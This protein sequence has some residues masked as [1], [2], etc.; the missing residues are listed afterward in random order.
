MA[1][2]TVQMHRGMLRLSRILGARVDNNHGE[3]LGRI[4]D[5]IANLYDG[6]VAAVVLSFRD[7]AEIS[8]K[9]VAVPLA[10]L[11][12]ELKARNLH[13]NVARETLHKAPSFRSDDW[14]DLIDRLWTAER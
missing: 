10:A 4:E 11:N 3:L 14:P 8:D 6:H 12:A 1:D 9:L 2:T 13:L 5:I 7:F